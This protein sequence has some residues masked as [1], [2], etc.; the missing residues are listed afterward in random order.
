MTCAARATRWSP[1]SACPRP[2][3][4]AR[5]W[6]GR[7]SPTACSGPVC[8]SWSPRSRSSPPC[9]SRSAGREG[10][11]FLLTAV[12]I[13]G[14]HGDAVRIAVPQRAALEH[15]PAFSLTTTNASSTPYTLAIMTL[16][17]GGLHA[18]RA[19]LPDVDVLGVPAAHQPDRHPGSDRVA[20][21]NDG[22]RHGVRGGLRHRRRSA[23][24]MK[25]LDPRLLRHASAARRFVILAAA[26]AVLT[27]GL[28]LV[29]AQLLA[30]ASPAPS[31]VA[32]RWSRW[33]RC[34]SALL[35]GRRRP[36]GARVAG[37]VAA[38]RASTDVIRQLRSSWSPTR[39]GWARATATC[40]RPASSPRWPPAALD[41]LE[42][43]FSRYLP[44]LLVAAVV[45][46]VVA[47]R[48]LFA[49][50]W[51]GG[52]RRRDGAAHPD[53]H[54]PRR[55]AHPLHAAAVAGPGRARPPL[56][57]PRRGPRRAGRVRPGTAPGVAPAQLAERSTGERP[58]RR[59]GWRSSP[60]S[61]S[62]CWPPSRSR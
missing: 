30:T 40:P 44:T 16:G 54:D 59:C 15:D 32:R 29:Q 39:C 56:P 55:A 13:V 37:E 50:C 60:R 28:V 9:S 17:G 42:G 20:R 7:S 61:S 41:G 53:L 22:P 2:C 45:P 5:S 38:H 12:A 25:P 24:T 48:I 46:A 21:R 31:S 58:C 34:W 33:P 62:S 3:S 49:D 35:V 26:T 57:R 4:A 43:Y 14:R 11:A 6:S 52:D 23:R 19:R 18:D 27:A 51:S 10:W 1:G 36:R 47:C 8:R